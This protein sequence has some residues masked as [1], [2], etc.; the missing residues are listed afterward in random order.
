MSRPV[1]TRARATATEFLR[2]LWRRRATIWTPTPTSPEEIFPLDLR[3]V[4]E[5]GLGVRF[6]DPE[7]IPPTA[8][9][10]PHSVPV[11]TAGFI[12]R[13]GDRIVV[14][15]QFPIDYRRFTGAHEVGHW[16]LHPK[17]KYHR[18][19]PLKGTERLAPKRPLE[20]YEADVFAAELLM[21]DKYLR[22]CFEARFR[23]TIHLSNL[24][25]NMAVWL[26]GRRASN[27]R[28]SDL[29]SRGQRYL[30]MQVATCRCFE[31]RHFESIADRFGVSPTAAAIR[32]E[33]L[34][35]VC[36]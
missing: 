34:R 22:K 6:D 9:A 33:E 12:D 14:A 3:A 1:A 32:L 30:A 8:P 23:E 20:E 36:A 5:Q 17:F 16:L 26:S 4:V 35:L 28:I 11:Q 21:P 10:A 18:D 19:R 31:S 2:N 15:Q 27:A 13:E 25:E 29:V 7:Y 24:D